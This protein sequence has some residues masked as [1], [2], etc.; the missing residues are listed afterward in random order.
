M[1][2]V[3][4]LDVF[5]GKSQALRDISLKVNEREIEGKGVPEAM[6]TSISTDACSLLEPLE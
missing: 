3:S 5:Y 2:E 1:L 6:G 4:N